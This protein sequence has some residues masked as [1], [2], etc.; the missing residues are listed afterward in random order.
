MSS[1]LQDVLEQVQAL[2]RH[3]LFGHL[4]LGQAFVEFLGGCPVLLVL[5]EVLGL[6]EVVLV[7]GQLELLEGVSP[8]LDEGVH[9]LEEVL[10]AGPPPGH[11][12]TLVL[13]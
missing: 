2:C 7:L 13:F 3:T 10:L 8:G 9:A 1:L 12:L 4:V 6:G 5:Q 11:L